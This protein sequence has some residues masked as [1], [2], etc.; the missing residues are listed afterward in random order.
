MKKL[1]IAAA[2]VCAAAFAQA[3]AFQWKQVND[4]YCAPGTTSYIPDASYTAYLFDAGVVSQDDLVKSW[5][6]TS[7][8][9][10]SIAGASQAVNNEDGISTKAFTYDGV[11]VGKDLNA[12][13]AFIFEDKLFV[14]DIKAGLA[15]ESATTTMSFSDPFD[16]SQLP[17]MNAAEGFNGQGWYTAVPEPTSGLLLLLGVA[18]LALK[19]RRA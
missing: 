4:G 8:T 14:S 1:M 7:F 5:N 16:D 3:S 10:T 11:A 2:I 17:A 12:Y 18:G 9:G 6:G 13:Y 15:Q 19:R